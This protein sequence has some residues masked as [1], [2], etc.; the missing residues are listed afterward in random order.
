[1]LYSLPD[2]LWAFA[3]TII[4]IAIWKGN[5]SYLRFFWYV[6]IPTLIFGFELLQLSGKFPGTFCI[7]DLAFCLAGIIAGIIIAKNKNHTP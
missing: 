2:G 5:K 6:S 3:Y 4:I 7:H 1:M